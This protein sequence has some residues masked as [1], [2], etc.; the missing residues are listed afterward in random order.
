MTLSSVAFQKYII[1][2]KE[3][4]MLKLET[5]LML[6]NNVLRVWPHKFKKWTKPDLEIFLGNG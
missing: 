4:K 3:I 6:V 5:L 2:L 1:A